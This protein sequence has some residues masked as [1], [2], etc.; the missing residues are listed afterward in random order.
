MLALGCEVEVAVVGSPSRLLRA[1]G[2]AW[3]RKRVRPSRAFF[4]FFLQLSSRSIWIFYEK[5]SEARAQAWAWASGPIDGEEPS[6][7]AAKG[8]GR[9][10][11][12]LCGAASTLDQWGVLFFCLKGCC[13]TFISFFFFP[14]WHWETV[15]FFE[16]QQRRRITYNRN[17]NAVMKQWGQNKKCPNWRLTHIFYTTN[18]VQLHVF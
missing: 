12:Q 10:G 15:F 3:Q 5:Q 16:R 11:R 14:I 13:V 6:P 1:A 9:C 4:F 2:G 18:L 17:E 8:T 7:A